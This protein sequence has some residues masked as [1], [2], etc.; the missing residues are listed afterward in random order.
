MQKKTNS[1]LEGVEQSVWLL[2]HLCGAVNGEGVASSAIKMTQCKSCDI[3]S[4][5][6]D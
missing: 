4:L 6:C 3:Y 2:S 1:K 5:W